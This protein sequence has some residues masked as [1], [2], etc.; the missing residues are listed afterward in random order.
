MKKFNK[1]HLILGAIFGFAAVVLYS[2][3]DI[4]GGGMMAAAVIGLSISYIM[5]KT[6]IKG[7]LKKD[8]N[9]KLYKSSIYSAMLCKD[10]NIDEVASTMNYLY[11]NSISVR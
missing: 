8:P 4:V 6:I 10:K 3:G 1:I 9:C 2:Y 7:E 5:R 11:C